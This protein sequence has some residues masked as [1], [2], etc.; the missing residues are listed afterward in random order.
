MRSTLSEAKACQIHCIMKANDFLSLL[1]EIVAL[2]LFY[3]RLND[4]QLNDDVYNIIFKDVT[5]TDGK[6]EARIFLRNS[7]KDDYALTLRQLAGLR[8]ATG[9]ITAKWFDEFRD[10]ANGATFQDK[11]REL[12]EAGVSLDTVKFR[13]VAQLTVRNEFSPVANTPVYQ[14]RCYVGST[15]YSMKL[16][17]LVKGKGGDFYATPE[18]SL[19]VRELR[20]KLHATALKPGKNIDANLVKLPVFEVI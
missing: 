17:E 5:T 9:P 4:V 13:V 2:Q 6:S 15:E 7:K 11:A 12:A 1:S 14:D 19:G 16:R 10:D 8:I 20:E 3:R 18:Y